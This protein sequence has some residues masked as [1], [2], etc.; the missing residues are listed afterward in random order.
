MGDKCSK[1]AGSNYNRQCDENPANPFANM[2]NLNIQQ[3][4]LIHLNFFVDFEKEFPI[5]RHF[6]L[7]DYMYL[8]NSFRSDREM[9]PSQVNDIT[10]EYLTKDDWMRFFDNKILMNPII[11]KLNIS[12]HEITCQKQFWDDLFDDV[13]SV[14]TMISGNDDAIEIPKSVFFAVGF[15]Y[16]KDKISQKI[17]V[18]INLFAGKDNKIMLDLSLYCFCFLIFTHILITPIRMFEKYCGADMEKSCYL[19]KIKTS[20][21]LAFKN[22]MTQLIGIRTSL[23][24]NLV[25]KYFKPEDK[26]YTKD[27]FKNHIMESENNW[28][29]SNN[30]IKAKIEEEIKKNEVFK[31]D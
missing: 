18:M 5:L 2:D 22:V 16:C 25:D 7:S 27:E 24:N 9:N 26:T 15:L 12:Q 13:K 28:I 19:S 21:V 31:R 11:T 6:L 30:N 1:L 4:P 8:L 17:I 3:H 23:A 10:E 29:F 20:N 14:Y